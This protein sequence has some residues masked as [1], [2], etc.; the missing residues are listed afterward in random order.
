MRRKRDTIRDHLANSEAEQALAEATMPTWW[1]DGLDL[2][3]EDTYLDGLGVEVTDFG[4]AKIDRTAPNKS[5]VVH[6]T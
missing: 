4:A 5:G 1:R 2:Y 3:V 6:P